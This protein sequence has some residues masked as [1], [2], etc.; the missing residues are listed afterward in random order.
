[1]VE[2]CRQIVEWLHI[3]IFARIERLLA[4]ASSLDRCLQWSS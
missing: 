2:S 4:A 3:A 1:V